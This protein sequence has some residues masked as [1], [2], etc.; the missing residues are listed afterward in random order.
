MCR[1][2]MCWSMSAPPNNVSRTMT[3]YAARW[4]WANTAWVPSA[5]RNASML[6]GVRSLTSARSMPGRRGVRNHQVV[7]RSVERLARMPQ[8]TVVY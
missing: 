5:A 2:R 8:P 7:T 3:R 4:S 6:S 1:S